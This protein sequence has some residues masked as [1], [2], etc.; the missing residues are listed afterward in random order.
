MN[1]KEKLN[2]K[3]IKLL[4]LLLTSMLIATVSAQV[5]NYM[6]IQGSGVVSLTKGL[7]WDLGTD[8]P[9]PAPTIVGYT[10][11]NLNFST[12]TTPNNYTDCLHI[13]N[14][15]PAESHIFNLKVKTSAGVWTDYQ[16]FNLVVFNALP[17]PAGAGVQQAV[18]NLKTQG[19]QTSDM[20]IPQGATWY[21]LFEI[22]PIA[23][24]TGGVKGIFEVEL[25]YESAA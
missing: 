16:E 3:P 23:S 20:T 1:I 9:S 12:G 19:A 18:L 15:D 14:Q 4:A 7:K 22:V 25:T 11:T 10:V 2:K 21:I 13:V 17:P 8:L 24:P 6:F 5:Y